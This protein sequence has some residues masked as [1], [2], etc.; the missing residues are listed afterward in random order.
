MSASKSAS[1]SAARGKDLLAV[2]AGAD[3]FK[4]L[5]AAIKAA[6]WSRRSR[7]RAFTVFAPTDEAFAKL[8]P[9]RWK[10]C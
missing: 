3:N 9:A 8:P 7:A 5:V 10:T 4:T 1:T 6:A 2:A